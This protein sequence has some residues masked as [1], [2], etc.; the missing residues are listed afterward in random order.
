LTIRCINYIVN[1]QSYPT[2]RS[3]DLKSGIKVSNVVSGL[4]AFTALMVFAHMIEPPSLSSSRSTE[5]ITACFTFIKWMAVLS[6]GQIPLRSEEHT[7][8]LQSRENLVCR[9]LLEK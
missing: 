4:S 8:E 6:Y 7:S 3:S 1:L 2:R 5:V 9:L